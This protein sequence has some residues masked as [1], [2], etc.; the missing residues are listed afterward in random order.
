MT[1]PRLVTQIL[2][3][4][5]FYVIMQRI[6]TVN[7]QRTLIEELHLQMM[8]EL[9]EEEDFNFRKGI[10]LGLRLALVILTGRWGASVTSSDHYYRIPEKVRDIYEGPDEDYSIE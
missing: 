2:T 6:V 8:D 5:I 7:H 4:N 9:K 1:E 10:T 3:S